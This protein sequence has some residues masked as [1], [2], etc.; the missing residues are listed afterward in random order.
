MSERDKSLIED[1]VNALH[2]QTSAIQALADSNAALI[3]AMAEADDDEE[4]GPAHYLD[5]TSCL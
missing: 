4:S 2:Q 1:L 3:L 5:G